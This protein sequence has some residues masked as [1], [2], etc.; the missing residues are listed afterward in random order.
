MKRKRREIMLR[1]RAG[2][3]VFILLVA[4]AASVPI[5]EA[6]D[7]Q[8]FRLSPAEKLGV[9]TEL[10]ESAGLHTPPQTPAQKAQ[11]ILDD[12]KRQVSFFGVENLAFQGKLP[13]IAGYLDKDNYSVHFQAAKLTGATITDVP[14]HTTTGPFVEVLELDVK[15]DGAT[16]IAVCGSIEV[17]R[18]NASAGATAGDDWIKISSQDIKYDPFS[19]A[20]TTLELKEPIP[21]T[22]AGDKLAFAVYFEK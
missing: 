12:E 17:R 11:D 4:V 3:T 21:G 8:P 14:F 1:N 15:D 10:V 13:I 6:Q 18:A 20:K 16:T 7:P 22:A 9:L 19:Y 2:W 5:A